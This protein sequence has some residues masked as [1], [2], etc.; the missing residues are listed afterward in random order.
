MDQMGTTERDSQ[1]AATLDTGILKNRERKTESI[2]GSKEPF[3]KTSK[4]RRKQKK[5]P[6]SP[7]RDAR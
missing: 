5:D 2:H 4:W 7:R 1:I 3:L 6:L